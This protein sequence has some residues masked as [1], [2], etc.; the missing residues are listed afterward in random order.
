MKNK[1]FY[2]AVLVLVVIGVALAALFIQRDPQIL[3]PGAPGYL[4][5]SQQ[6]GA[7]T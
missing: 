1:I 4:T 3:A 5:E 6:Q 7:L 2:I